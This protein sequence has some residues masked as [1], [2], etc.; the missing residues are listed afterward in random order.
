M[1]RPRPIQ[2]VHIVLSLRLLMYLVFQPQPLHQVHDFYIMF[3]SISISEKLTIH[4]NDYLTRAEAHRTPYV[5]T[6]ITR[7]T[8]LEDLF[9]FIYTQLNHT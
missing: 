3:Y 2:E 6:A 5:S 4:S 9:F 1:D 8:Y 7:M